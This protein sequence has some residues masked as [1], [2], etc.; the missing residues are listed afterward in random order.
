MLMR[1][2][3]H[4]EQLV[5]ELSAK[6][7]RVEARLAHQAAKTYTLEEIAHTYRKSVDTVRRWIRDEGLPAQ[8]Q[9]YKVVRAGDLHDWINQFKPTLMGLGVGGVKVN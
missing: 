4:Q 8:G 1:K 5:A 3:G 2:L 6:L 9:R 7:D